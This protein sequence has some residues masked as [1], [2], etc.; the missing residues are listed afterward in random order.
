MSRS[1]LFRLMVLNLF[2]LILWACGQEEGEG[3][4]VPPS[5]RRGAAEPAAMSNGPVETW[6][7]S[8]VPL[9]Q[10]GVREGEEP[11]QLHRALGSVRLEDGSLVVLNAGSQELRYFDSDGRFLQS[12]G[13]RGEGPGEFESPVSLRKT[14][15]GGLQV[16]DRGLL[17]ASVFELEGAYRESFP[18]LATREELFPGDDWLLGQNWI[19]SPVPPGARA[20]IRRAVESM[21]PLE[22]AGVLR[23]ILVSAQGRIWAPRVRPPADTPVDWDIYDLYGRLVARITTPARF[24]P[25]EIG[26]D[27]LTGLFLD[28]MDVNYIQVYGLTK[29]PGSPVGPGLD[30]TVPAEP[31]EEPEHPFPPDETMAEIRSLIK[32]MA[33]LEEIHYSEN[34][35]YTSDPD[36][37]FG[38]SRTRMPPGLQ[39]DILFAG[40]E[41]WAG[42]V[43]D[44]GSGA[45]CVLAYGFYVPM[46]W[47]P[48]AVICI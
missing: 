18:V 25:Q 6:A 23:L 37:L 9:L 36:V 14:Q 8:P 40:E 17:R 12:V 7:L 42:M 30:T 43:T 10:I 38:E 41:G 24:Q 22:S 48:G 45:R 31:E 46:G 4:E 11:Y 13:G 20:P 16:W 32:I 35:T 1:I 21:P 5:A 2:P 34:Y 19:V 15:D 3:G 28:E 33:S 44:P 39:V 26:E 29:P 47:Q 27:F